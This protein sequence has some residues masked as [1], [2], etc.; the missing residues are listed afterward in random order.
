M[1]SLEPVRRLEGSKVEQA[2]FEADGPPTI[3]LMVGVFGP[4]G[5][6]FPPVDVSR[7][8]IPLF[9]ALLHDGEHADRSVS[10]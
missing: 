9:V 7:C 10:E 2:L 5:E 4:W 6:V 3:P 8:F 1:H